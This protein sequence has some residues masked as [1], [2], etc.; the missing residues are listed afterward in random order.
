MTSHQNR[1]RLSYALL[2][3]TQRN[4]EVI[5]VDQQGTRDCGPLAEG[6]VKFGP[7]LRPAQVA[8]KQTPEELF[9]RM[10]R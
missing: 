3:K 7:R 4:K 6:P 2:R 1:Q 10:R 8:L 9:G 5:L